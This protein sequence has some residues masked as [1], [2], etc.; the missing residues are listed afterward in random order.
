MVKRNQRGKEGVLAKECA[1]KKL[2]R[3]NPT[4]K[5][6][7]KEH[8]RASKQKVRKKPGVLAKESAEKKQDK[9]PHLKQVKKNTSALQSRKPERSQVY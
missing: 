9:T 8:M 4:F 5:A 2:A 7:E 6:S 3:Q 1:E